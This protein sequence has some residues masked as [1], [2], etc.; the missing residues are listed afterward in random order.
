MNHLAWR[1]A[2]LLER[3]PCSP[4]ECHQNEQQQCFSLSPLPFKLTRCMPDNTSGVIEEVAGDLRCDSPVIPPE[5]S[6][7]ELDKP[8]AERTTNRS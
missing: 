3:N 4:R 6:Y 8:T 1:K 2:R 7:L 5:H